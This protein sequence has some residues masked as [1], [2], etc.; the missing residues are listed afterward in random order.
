MQPDTWLAHRHSADPSREERRTPPFLQPDPSQYLPLPS[1]S[2]RSTGG[3]FGGSNW[4]ARRTDL[5]RT[6]E[7][8]AA[9]LAALRS[10]VCKLE[11]VARSPL[12]PPPPLASAYTNTKPQLLPKR[13]LDRIE[14][15]ID[16]RIRT[17]C[18]VGVLCAVVYFALYHLAG[19][20]IPFFLAVSLKYI[21]TPL[22]DVL[23]CRHPLCENGRPRP[24]WLVELPRKWAVL[25]ALAI[26]L[27]VLF[28][29]GLTVANSLSA[30]A[31][32]AG[33]YNERIDEL[34]D[35]FF[36]KLTEVQIDLGVINATDHSGERQIENID[37]LKNAVVE[38]I[39]ASELIISFL[40]TATS[41]LENETFTDYDM[42]LAFLAPMLLAFLNKDVFA[43]STNL[44]S[45]GV[46]LSILLWGSVWG[47]TGMVLAV[48]ITAVFRIHLEHI[49]HPLPRYLAGK[50]GKSTAMPR[51]TASARARE[52]EVDVAAVGP[53]RQSTHMPVARPGGGD[54]LL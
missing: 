53:A 52:T 2:E 5:E 18:L 11:G 38:K 46:M 43:S 34:I 10:K 14:G 21:L 48:P 12:P 31:S 54:E 3:W 8:Q 22:I 13:P 28:V 49:Q 7:A 37:L 41:V 19:T 27:F 45:V 30:F 42:L 25:F 15:L 47:I 26:A 35:W 20:L 44:D 17:L 16:E 1:L 33:V 24:W 4:W 9:E 23:S 51:D 29:V 50:L 36:H 39:D 32:R 40:G 6:V